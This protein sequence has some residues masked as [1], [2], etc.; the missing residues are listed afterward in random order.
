MNGVIKLLEPYYPTLST[1]VI[2]L[3]L[4]IKP[5]INKNLFWIVFVDYDKIT[6]LPSTIR[7]LILSSFTRS[8]SPWYLLWLTKIERGYEF[9]VHRCGHSSGI[10]LWFCFVFFFWHQLFYYT[11]ISNKLNLV[12]NYVLREV[13][14]SKSFFQQQEKN[15][16]TRLKK[17]KS[18]S[19]VKA[20]HDKRNHEQMSHKRNFEMTNES[21]W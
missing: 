16:R 14:V 8:L 17:Q 20:L 10:L 13:T 1:D 4:D 15:T 7:L 3:S 18:F 21:S 11:S 5:L 19:H 12:P 6:H 2:P 9:I